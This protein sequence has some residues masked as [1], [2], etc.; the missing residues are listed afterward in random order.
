MPA[1]LSEKL[2]AGNGHAV[3]EPVV[4]RRL[5]SFLVQ[6]SHPCVPAGHGADVDGNVPAP[7]NH[8][9]GADQSV[10]CAGSQVREAVQTPGTVLAA[11]PCWSVL[12]II[13]LPDAIGEGADLIKQMSHRNTQNKPFFVITYRREDHRPETDRKLVQKAV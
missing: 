6:D 4:R 5:E 13:G 1:D 3:L 11:F 7:G 12:N 9:L 2:V 8:G 10:S